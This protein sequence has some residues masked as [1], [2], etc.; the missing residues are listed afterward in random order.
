MS[1]NEDFSFNP[2]SASDFRLV[3]FLAQAKEDGLPVVL[4]AFGTLVKPQVEFLTKLAEGVRDQRWRVIWSLEYK[5]EET[6]RPPG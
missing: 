6:K 2:K 1:P 3:D 5:Q 4:V